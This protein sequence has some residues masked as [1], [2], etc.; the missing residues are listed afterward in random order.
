MFHL[1]SIVELARSFLA[2]FNH[3]AL[4]VALVREP[5]PLVDLLTIGP[6]ELAMTVSQI[7][8]KTPLVDSLVRQT[9]VSLTMHSSVFPLACVLAALRRSESTLSLENII[10][11][12]TRV[13]TFVRELQ[14]AS[15][16]P[17]TVLVKS[18]VSGAILPSGLTFSM[19]AIFYPLAFVCLAILE[20]CVLSHSMRFVIHELS[21]VDIAVSFDQPSLAASFPVLPVSFVQ[22]S[23][24]ELLLAS[25]ASLPVGVPLPCVLRAIRQN[26]LDSILKR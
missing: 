19:L 8:L 21:H 18:L 2:T 7:T 9:Q 3:E 24:S 12:F 4:S 13:D 10:H 17:H 22:V 26:G 11:E 14:S 1:D 23:F 15:A 25:A 20:N 16:A 5:T 6:S